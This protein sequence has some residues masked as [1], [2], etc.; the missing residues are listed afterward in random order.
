MFNAFQYEWGTV[1][2]VL[3]LFGVSLGKFHIIYTLP[4]QQIAMPC[5]GVSIW[6][7]R[8]SMLPLLIEPHA[9]SGTAAVTHVA[10]IFT[11]SPSGLAGSEMNATGLALR[12]E[13]V[14]CLV[15]LVEGFS[16]IWTRL[17]VFTTRL[18]ILWLLLRSREGRRFPY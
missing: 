6:M 14:A 9:T 12:S 13:Q 3:H 2:R 5:V 7:G 17:N 10:H 8:V 11:P 4:G 16:E 1:A 18:C 15:F